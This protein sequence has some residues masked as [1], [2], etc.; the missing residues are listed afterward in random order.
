ML[1]GRDISWH[2]DSNSPAVAVVNRQFA[3]S[4]FGSIQDAVGRY[5]KTQ[6]GSRVEVVG[7]VEDGKYMS[8][9]ENQEP[10]IFPSFLQAPTSATD[11]VVRSSLDPQQLGADIRSQLRVLD[12]GLPI[13]TA[14]WTTELDIVLFPARMATMALGALGLMGGILSITGI[15]GMAAYSV[16]RRLRELGIRIA[17][18]G[19]R[20]EVLHAALGRAVN[21]LAVGSVAGLV[22]GVLASRVLAFIVYQA[23]PRDP[24]VLGGVVL[25]MALLGLLAT[26]IP[27]RRALAVNPLMLLREE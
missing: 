2:D 22:L 14:T 10:A 4:M 13:D 7:V 19:R 20:K 17:L 26:W 5:Y 21:L 15:F 24:I 1:A 16:S 3:V 6:D 23:T 12:S 27:A 25:A 8:L 9:T 11:I 18:G